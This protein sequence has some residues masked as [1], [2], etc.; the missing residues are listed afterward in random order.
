VPALIVV[1]VYAPQPRP[2]E[3]SALIAAC[4]RAAAPNECVTSDAKSADPP[5]G[6]AIV[7]R[8]G[9]R[10][11]IELGMRTA[12]SAEW[13]TRDLIFQAGDDELERYRAIGFAI[14]TL[15]ARQAEP[16]PAPQ[17]QEPEPPPPAAPA[18]PPPPS[19]P[20]PRREGPRSEPTPVRRGYRSAWLDASASVGLGLI[21][22]PPRAGGELR[23]AL[24]LVPR[25]FFA[26]VEAGYAERLAADSLRVRWMHAS[27]GFGHPLVPSARDFGA[28]LR[29]LVSLERLAVTASDGARSAAGARWKPG[30][31]AAI[32]GYLYVAPPVAIL[33]GA[34]TFI[35][36]ERTVVRQA[37][38]EAGE[39]PAVGL[40]GFVGV[41]VKVR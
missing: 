27:A 6:V 20:P 23:A 12:P 32:D 22:G 17:A 19:E 7:R 1:E 24:E 38:V 34:S 37:G 33:V 39:T 2:Q 4:S 18:A 25:G 41:R 14:G 26:V 15:V 5:L 28:D 30:V 8:D 11:R 9:D 16:T 36:P 35:D 21:P 13:S 3:L 29:L 40:V 10:A 31:T